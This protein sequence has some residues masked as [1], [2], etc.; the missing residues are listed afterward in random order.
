MFML[1][2]KL[3]LNRTTIQMDNRQ[4]IQSY[5]AYKRYTGRTVSNAVFF[6]L[7]STK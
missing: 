2:F 7:N 4:N 3:Q 6:T 1:K 5:V